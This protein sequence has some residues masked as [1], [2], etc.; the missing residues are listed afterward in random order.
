MLVNQSPYEERG[1]DITYRKFRRMLY[2]ARYKRKRNKYLFSS[3]D[4]PGL[5][6]VK[7]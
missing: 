5:R 1:D 4:L 2:K 6:T 7:P 3:D